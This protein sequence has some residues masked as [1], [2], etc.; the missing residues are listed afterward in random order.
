MT[1]SEL[2]KVTIT[3]ESVDVNIQE[4]DEKGLKSIIRFAKR[5]PEDQMESFLSGKISEII[6]VSS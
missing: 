6:V 3:K 2:Y 4:H 5:I 1:N